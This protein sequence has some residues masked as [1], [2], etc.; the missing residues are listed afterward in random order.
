MI[1]DINFGAVF[2][3]ILVVGIF[4]GCM[5]PALFSLAPAD[6]MTH[7]ELEAAGHA[8]YY[9]DAD[10]Q[11]QWRLLPMGCGDESESEATP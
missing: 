11:R 1:P 5:I 9:L 6:S 4:I 2:A 8:E 10:H 7:A 3:C